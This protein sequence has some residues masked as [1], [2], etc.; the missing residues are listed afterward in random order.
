MIE[1]YFQN[2]KFFSGYVDPEYV[3]TQELTEKSDVYS[4][5]VVLLEIIT[6]RRAVHE[7][8]NLVEMSQRLLVNKT[9]H[10]DLVDPRI[11]DSIDDDDGGK[12]LE[13]VVAVVRLCT[14]KEGR[15]RPSIKKVLRLLCESCDPLHSGFAKAVEVEIIGRDSRNRTDSRY[16]R[17]NSRIFG[18]SSSTT[19]RSHC[20]RSLPHSPINGLS[21]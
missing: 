21:F 2:L 15:S 9:R 17:G 13:A 14:E 18:P 4:Y 8:M 19:S 16:Q 12:Q 11:K 10:R 1:T 6:G 3:V 5:G 7:G 20:S